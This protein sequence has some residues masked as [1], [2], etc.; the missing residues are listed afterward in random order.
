[1]W[2]CIH[3]SVLSMHQKTPFLCPFSR[4]FT[5]YNFT[6]DSF[7]QMCSWRSPSNLGT[8]QLPSRQRHPRQTT[9]QTEYVALNP[10]WK[11]SS[12]LRMINC[13]GKTTWNRTFFSFKSHLTL[14]TQNQ[15]W[16]AATAA[17][18]SRCIYRKCACLK[19]ESPIVASIYPAPTLPLLYNFTQLDFQV[20]LDLK[21]FCTFSLFIFFFYQHKRT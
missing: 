1:M 11:Y 13:K 4:S 7:T 14:A 8:V 6:S 17:I 16:C 21:G 20:S 19:V 3:A 12:M 2:R 5:E 15:L 9:V 18:H 10:T